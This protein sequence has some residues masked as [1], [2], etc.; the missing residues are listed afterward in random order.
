MH[1][2]N[3][4]EPIDKVALQSQSRVTYNV[5][6]SVGTPPQ[7][8]QVIFDTGSFML[9]VFA[10][11]PPAGMEPIMDAEIGQDAQV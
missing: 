1:S 6:L 3:S 10:R 8:L 4:R 7:P 11:P 9:A 5:K 2:Y